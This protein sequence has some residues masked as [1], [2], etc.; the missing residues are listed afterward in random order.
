MCVIYGRM[1]SRRSIDQSDII[2]QHP[3]KTDHNYVRLFWN[4]TRD[5]IV[6]TINGRVAR[7]KNIAIRCAIVRINKSLR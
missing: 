5:L 6:I 3:I 7:V 2:D 1:P 4:P